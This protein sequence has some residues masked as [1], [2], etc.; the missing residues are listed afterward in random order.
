MTVIR[1]EETRRRQEIADDRKF[2][3]KLSLSS[4][5]IGVA[6]GLVGAII[7]L[8]GAI[9]VA[10]QQLDSQEQQASQSFVRDSRKE[11]YGHVI[12][13]E[14]AFKEALDSASAATLAET[15]SDERAQDARGRVV[16]AKESL[17]NALA[18]VSILG[19]EHAGKLG[20]ALREELEEYTFQVYD[21]MFK[22]S[23]GGKID[24]EAGA[25]RETAAD[26]VDSASTDFLS[27]VRK[28][29]NP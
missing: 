22:R 29:L 2:Q 6:G 26:R 21:A 5:L 25:S 23:Q 11:A 4:G 20:A 15:Y 1:P 19:S 17:L 3:R 16:T 12:S 18:E 28:E 27:A 10:N 7:G 8:A 13:A 24:L 9:V 14:V